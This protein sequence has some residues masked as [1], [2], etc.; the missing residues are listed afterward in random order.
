MTLGAPHEAGGPDKADSVQ[1]DAPNKRSL[2]G[3]IYDH[4]DALAQ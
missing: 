1:M 4:P 3:I 2:S